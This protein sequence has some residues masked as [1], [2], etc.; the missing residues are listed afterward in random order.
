MDKGREALRRGNPQV[1]RKAARGGPSDKRKDTTEMR[2]YPPATQKAI[3]EA[4]KKKIY[5]RTTSDR[6]LIFLVING[7]SDGWVSGRALAVATTHKA[8]SRLSDMRRKQGIGYECRPDPESP[9]HAQWMEYRLTAV[10]D[11]E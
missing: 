8:S 10:G 5:N 2:E 11:A 7:D 6:V 1:T 4:F 9:G 3:N